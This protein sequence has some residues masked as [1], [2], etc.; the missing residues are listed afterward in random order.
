MSD[1]DTDAR[2]MPDPDQPT[3]EASGG[4][5]EVAETHR[6]HQ[7]RRSNRS[8]VTNITITPP[9]SPPNEPANMG[10]GSGGLGTKVKKMRGYA[11]IFVAVTLIAVCLY[12]IFTGFGHV[13]CDCNDLRNYFCGLLG[14]C[15]M[16]L[17]GA[18]KDELGK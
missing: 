13:V 5:A 1:T 17:T 3:E 11:A 18:V 4:E 10:S 16:F 12:G 9:A 8:E 2:S 7:H 6:H 14:A 15:L